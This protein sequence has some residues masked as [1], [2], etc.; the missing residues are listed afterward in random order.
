MDPSDADATPS[1]TP[2]EEARWRARTNH[3]AVEYYRE[4]SRAP[5]VAEGGGTRNH[6]CMECDG[7]IPLDGGG[8][9]VRC[10]HCGATLAGEAQRFFNWV[11]LDRPPRSDARALAP[12][13]LGGLLLLA[14]LVLG[15]LRCFA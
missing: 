3:E 1:R 9:R 14:V 8:D 4:R 10:P 15:S 5:G 12:L 6:Y 13:A 11:E 2:A 7:V